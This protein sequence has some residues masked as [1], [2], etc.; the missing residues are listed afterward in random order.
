MYRGQKSLPAPIS[1]NR[2][3]YDFEIF[4]LSGKAN[5]R[6]HKYAEKIRELPSIFKQDAKSFK[7]YL[8]IPAIAVA[9]LNFQ[10]WKL[11]RAG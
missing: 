5:L 4:Q 3:Y 2:Q 8:T 11:L 7:P 1:S 10:R 9:L 6:N